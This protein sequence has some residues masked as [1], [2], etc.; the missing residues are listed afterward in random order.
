MVEKKEKASNLSQENFEYW[1][2]RNSRKAWG[3]Y[4]IG[5][6]HW[7]GFLMLFAT[8]MGS[9]WLLVA[10][11]LSV[12]LGTA[13]IESIIAK[14]GAAIVGISLV[15]AACWLGW[16]GYRVMRVRLDPERTSSDHYRGWFGK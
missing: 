3:R 16:T 7:K 9:I 6:V 14:V 15:A 4:S 13:M 10:G 8:I 12:V 1:F 11:V 2:A 5:V